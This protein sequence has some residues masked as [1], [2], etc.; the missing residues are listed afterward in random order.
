LG[1]SK[2]YIRFHVRNLRVWETF[3]MGSSRG[4]NNG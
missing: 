1:R 2:K 4:C 3:L